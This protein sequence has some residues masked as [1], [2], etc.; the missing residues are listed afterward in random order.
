MKRIL[1]FA[2]R[3]LM[4]PVVSGLM[5]C[6]DMND[7]QK[8][9]VEMGSRIYAGKIDSL[10]V[11]GGDRRVRIE[12]LM[13]YAYT[14][15]KC[16]IKWEGDSI[17]TSLDGY[18]K[19]DTFSIIISD[20]EEGTWLFY[21]RTLDRE[22][23]SS[24]QETCMGYSYGEQYIL[25]ADPK[26]VLQMRAEPSGMVLLW[27][28]SED[29]VSVEVA[30]ESNTGEKTLTLPGDV[31][32]TGLPDWKL[33]GYVKT[34]TQLLPEKDAIDMLY[35]DWVTQYFPVFVEFELDKSKIVPLKLSKDATTGYSGKIEGVFDGV[36]NT[37]GAQ[38]HSGDGVGVPQHLTFD[39]GVSTTLTRLEMWARSD[40]YN[41]WNPKKIQFWGIA[42]M[43]DAEITLPSMDAGWEA[44]AE[45]KGW[46]KLLEGTCNDPVNNRLQFDAPDTRMRYL[47]V[48]TTE[49]Y[50]GPSSGSGAYV[51]LKEITLYANYIADLHD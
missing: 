44:E 1:Y 7:T 33:G 22:G 31:K 26:L 38:F 29:A 35:T 45:A 15:E 4:P 47:I 50:G 13:Y 19:D 46:K 36:L 41:N 51:I 16:I 9:F 34:R 3:Y 48:R 18:A 14:A 10:T 12:G 37:G 20:L 32:E 24:L 5:G 39:L 42:D 8:E 2:L 6:S 23:N 25:S 43:T 11:H 28:T 21:V 40:G 30:Y 27:N 49:V 17:I